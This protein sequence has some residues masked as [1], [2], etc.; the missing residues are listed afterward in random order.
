MKVCQLCHKGYS[1]AQRRNKIKRILE[2]KCQSEEDCWVLQDFKSAFSVEFEITQDH[3][4]L[5]HVFSAL[6]D[7]L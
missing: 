4:Q 3:Q 7:D 6:R 2:T 1:F 5:A